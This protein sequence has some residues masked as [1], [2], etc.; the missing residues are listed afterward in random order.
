MNSI[1]FSNNDEIIEYDIIEKGWRGDILVEINK[2]FYH[3]T[4]ITLD[5][6]SKEFNDAVAE[7]RIYNIDTNIVLVTETSRRIIIETLLY[8]IDNGYFINAKPVDLNEFLLDFDKDLQV[9][10]SWVKVY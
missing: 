9:I 7:N 4:V 6:L 8:L 5:R 3:L 2:N 10:E 1:Y